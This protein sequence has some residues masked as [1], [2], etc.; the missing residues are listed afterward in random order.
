MAVIWNVSTL[1]LHDVLKHIPP[2]L[3]PSLSCYETLSCQVYHTTAVPNLPNAVV[4]GLKLRMTLS[5]AVIQPGFRSGILSSAKYTLI[6]KVTLPRLWVYV[7]INRY[8]E[9]TKPWFERYS[10]RF[11]I[12]NWYP[13]AHATVVRMPV[14]WNIR[15]VTIL[16]AR[17]KIQDM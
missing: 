12:I 14:C 17:H 15:L 4:A 9:K 11:P 6:L 3:P 10:R 16:S 13:M 7:L 8:E 1:K 5:I 2:S